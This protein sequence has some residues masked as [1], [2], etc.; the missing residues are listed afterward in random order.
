MPIFADNLSFRHK[1]VFVPEEASTAR[2]SI[3]SRIVQFGC[4]TIAPGAIQIVDLF[5]ARQHVWD[6]ARKLFPLDKAG[7]ERWITIEQAHLDASKIEEL[8]CSLRSIQV[9][10]QDLSVEL[11][12]Q[13][14]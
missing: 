10:G 8:I 2:S 4:D 9:R 14:E 3:C 11:L 12:T 5:H 13:A 6:L 7:R 1:D